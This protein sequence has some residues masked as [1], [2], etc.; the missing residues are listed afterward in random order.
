MRKIVEYNYESIYQNNFKIKL[1]KVWVKKNDENFQ[2]QF[3]V[4]L[5]NTKFEWLLKSPRRVL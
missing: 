2:I 3:L 5:D 1:S 4:D